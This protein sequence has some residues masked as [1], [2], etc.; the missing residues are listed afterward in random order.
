MSEEE[1]QRLR[2]GKFCLDDSP[3][4]KAAQI[5]ADRS[6]LIAYLEYAL[7]DVIALSPSSVSLLRALL[8]DIR[9][10]SVAA[11]TTGNDFRRPS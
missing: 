8:D 10:T 9:H 3:S 6:Q 7:Q 4:H 1:T 5:R 11:Q 2:H